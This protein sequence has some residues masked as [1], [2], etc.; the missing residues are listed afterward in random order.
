[1]SLRKGAL[2]VLLCSVLAASLTLVGCARNVGNLVKPGTLTVGSDCNS[3]PF[4]S[5][6]GTTLVG[7]EYELMQAIGKEMGLKVEYLAPQTFDSILVQVAAGVKMDIGVSSIAITSDRKK[8][9]DFCLPY[10]VVNQAIVTLK[11]DNY[12][13]YHDLESKT[14]GA[15]SGSTGEAWALENIS[16]V[17]IKTYTQASG[18]LLALLAGDIEAVVLDELV[19]AH[20]LAE[21]TYSMCEIIHVAAT[22]EQYGFAVAQDNPALRDAVNKAL[23]KLKQNGTF[24]TL[25]RKYFPNVDPPPIKP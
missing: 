10:C 23:V 15:Q 25:F 4:I 20:L 8:L 7:F 16:D 3:P 6:E 5:M 1:M 18:A 2:V 17:T 21:T 13:S 14:V 12:S 11:A 24:D 19:A 9:V 22:A